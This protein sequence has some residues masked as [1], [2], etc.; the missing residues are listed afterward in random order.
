[1][2]LGDGIARIEIEEACTRELFAKLWP[3]TQGRRVR[4][5]RFA[6]ED[7][8]HVWEIDAFKD[9]DLYLAEVELDSPEEEVV[10]PEWLAPYVEREVTTDPTY[11]NA[12]L[13]R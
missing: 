11:V 4:K 10:L 12:N 5:R 6:I 2:K 9:R 13:A 8:A 7:G 3:L 1:V